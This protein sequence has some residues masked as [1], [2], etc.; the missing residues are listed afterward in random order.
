MSPNDFVAV[1][2]IGQYIGTGS[3]GSVYQGVCND[4]EVAVKIFRSQI[5][6]VY[7]NIFVMPTVID[8]D[9]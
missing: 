4:E 5:L 7:I 8:V 6:Q 3:F 9:W 1:P 2:T